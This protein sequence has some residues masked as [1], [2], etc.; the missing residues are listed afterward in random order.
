M[1]CQYTPC[2]RSRRWGSA[3]RRATRAGPRVDHMW[4]QSPA[5]QGGS[6]R[7]HSPAADSGEL[8]RMTINPT[9]H[10]VND[11][12]TIALLDGNHDNGKDVR[13]PA[14][15]RKRSWPKYREVVMRCQLA[16]LCRKEPF[17]ASYTGC[18]QQPW[19]LQ[20]GYSDGTTHHFQ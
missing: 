11:V 20:H 12:H 8:R 4:C 9:A 1:G 13:A 15:R 17:G 19:E 14:L 16:D 2:S 7:H 18:S 5:M 6:C 3:A 10:G